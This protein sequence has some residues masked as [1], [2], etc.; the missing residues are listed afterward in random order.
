[1]TAVR[2][3]ERRVP[4]A[5]KMLSPRKFTRRQKVL[6]TV[7]NLALFCVAWEVFVRVTGMPSLL[8]P[9]FSAV[10]AEIP[11][12]QRQGILLPNIWISLK[13]YLFGMA[14][15]IVAAVP[16]GL[17]I[18]GV[19]VIDRLLA[20][21]MWALYTLPRLILMPL[22]LLWVGIND[23]ARVTLIVLSAVPAIV[24]VVMDGVKTVD[25]SL[26]RAARSFCA[27]RLQV[28]THVAMP[29]T[30][31]FI[32]TGIRMGVSRG[33]IGLFIGEL[34]TAANGVGY[35]MVTAGRSFDSARV[36][37][38]LFIFVGFSVAVVGLTQWLE[39]KASL[40]RST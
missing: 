21:Y 13:L 6:L 5:A 27:N 33:L 2:N 12:M 1:M 18:G 34:F 36:Y 40:W 3:E 11:E 22:I 30:V 16:L 15:S 29:A 35:I 38:M 17:I 25:G 7:A 10:L 37:L 4:R 32:A 20:P 19:Q 14:I 9:K 8:V 24:V 23:A 39:G 26:L 28:L 31:P